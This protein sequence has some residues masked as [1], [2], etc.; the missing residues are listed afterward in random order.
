[1]TINVVLAKAHQI[2]LINKEVEKELADIEEQLNKVNLPFQENTINFVFVNGFYLHSERKLQTV[3][4]FVNKMDKPINELH[5]AIRL[6]F[7]DRMAQIAKTVVDFDEPFLG[8]LNPDEALLVHL[9]IPVKGLSND[10]NFTISDI[11]GSFSDVRVT[12]V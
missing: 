9:N 3:C 1:M 10:E 8:V 6:K 5:G 4:L 2:Q 11:S 7:N 12:S